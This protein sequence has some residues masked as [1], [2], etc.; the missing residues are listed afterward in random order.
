[1]LGEMHGGGWEKKG[2]K[3]KKKKNPERRPVTK[4]AAG[5]GAEPRALRAAGGTPGCAVCDMHSRR[6][7]K[8]RQRLGGDSAL[9]EKRVSGSGH[10]S[11]K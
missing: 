11:N 4:T 2:K 6:R 3:R 9:V 8:R 1:M 10:E 7:E 5:R